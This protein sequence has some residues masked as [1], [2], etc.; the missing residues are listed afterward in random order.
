MK[1]V[2]IP[3]SFLLPSKLCVFPLPVEPKENTEMLNP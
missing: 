3:G 1:I 2:I